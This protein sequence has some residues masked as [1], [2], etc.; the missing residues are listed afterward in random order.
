MSGQ[1]A[2]ADEATQNHASAQGLIRH[3]IPEIPPAKTMAPNNKP[4]AGSDSIRTGKAL[5]RQ[6]LEPEGF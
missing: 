2:G 3:D 5:N 6:S 4:E 1:A